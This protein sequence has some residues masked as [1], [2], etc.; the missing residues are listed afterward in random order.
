MTY[1]INVQ[2]K[3]IRT[4]LQALS[5]CFHYDEW[6]LDKRPK[7]L[8]G[9]LKGMITQTFFNFRIANSYFI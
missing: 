1:K 2:T 5:L 8:K 7:P 4:F 9:L 6:N 3:Y